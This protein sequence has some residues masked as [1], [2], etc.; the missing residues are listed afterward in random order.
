MIEFMDALAFFATSVGAGVAGAGMMWLVLHVITRIPMVQAVGSLLTQKEEGSLIAGALVHLL[1][2]VFFGMLYTL[3]ILAVPNMSPWV[4][5][6]FGAMLGFFHGVTTSLILV[7]AV[8]ERH[9]VE[10]FR[11]SGFSI[12]MAHLAGHVAFGLAAATVVAM[13]GISQSPY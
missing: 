12:A 4:I 7:F 1:S 13:S 10:R 9:P 3:A 5:L 6:G 8:A 2:A 11:D